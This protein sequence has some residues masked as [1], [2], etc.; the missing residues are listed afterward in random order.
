MGRISIVDV[1]S[2]FSLL[3]WWFYFR[4]LSYIGEQLIRLTWLMTIIRLYLFCFPM[5]LEATQQIDRH[6]VGFLANESAD[7]CSLLAF[8][9][10][11]Y[12]WFPMFLFQYARRLMARPRKEGFSRY[13]WT[14]L[15]WVFIK[16]FLCRLSMLWGHAALSRLCL[17]FSELFSILQEIHLL[18]PAA[19][20]ATTRPAASSSLSESSSHEMKI[21][22]HSAYATAR[23]RW[24]FNIPE[25]LHFSS[26]G[27]FD[28]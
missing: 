20:A 13:W 14:R 1:C 4:R 8:T 9:G 11:I 2:P 25:G 21:S 22:M 15:F 7:D 23:W 17:Y 6:D 19:R 28:I 26:S 18:S 10:S 12:A 27:S 24:E 3:R 16:S 5:P